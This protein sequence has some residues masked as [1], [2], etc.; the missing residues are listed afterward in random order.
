MTK[1]GVKYRDEITHP[2]ELALH[3]L[4]KKSPED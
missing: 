4:K 3:Y 1:F 2:N